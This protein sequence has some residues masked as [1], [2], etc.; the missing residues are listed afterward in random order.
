[1]SAVGTIERELY[2]D[3]PP[4]LV[5][6]HFVDP[7][8]LVRWMGREATIDPRPH[9]DFCITYNGFDR[10]QGQFVELIPHT[11]IVFTWGW[12]TLG[13][14][15]PPLSTTVQV[16]FTPDGGG[17]RLRLVHSGFERSDEVEDH[18]TGWDL[19]LQFLVETCRTGLPAQL[20]LPRFP[21]QIVS[22]DHA[23]GE[24]A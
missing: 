1:M 22:R 12:A 20:S 17:T 3:A 4:A 7:E 13:T 10:M 15:S 14:Q 24:A 23:A 21:G 5:Y 8:K 16:T 9:G 6:S 2:I 19:F 11:R 18:S